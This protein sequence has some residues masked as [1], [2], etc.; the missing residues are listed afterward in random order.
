MNKL[1][2]SVSLLSSFVARTMLDDQNWQMFGFKS[3]PKRGKVFD[4]FISDAR[5]AKE[6]FVL[7]ELLLFSMTDIIQAIKS[8]EL[9]ETNKLLYLVGVLSTIFT[10]GTFEDE[11]EYFTFLRTGI[12]DYSGHDFIKTFAARA[13][14]AVGKEDTVRLIAGAVV[15][16]SFNSQEVG[17]IYDKKVLSQQVCL[18]IGEDHLDFPLAND[19]LEE[20]SD[21][22]RALVYG[23]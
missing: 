20:Y 13:E 9:E 5:L 18:E 7:R 3:R 10:G 17:L 1:N 6:K 12:L 16:K 23:E 4:N 21:F 15:L 2:Q 11:K 19:K 8:V 14:K 22:S